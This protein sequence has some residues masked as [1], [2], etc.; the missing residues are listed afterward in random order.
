M[1]ER[2][3]PYGGSYYAVYTGKL[4]GWWTDGRKTCKAT[5]FHRLLILIWRKEDFFPGN[6]KNYKQ[7][8]AL[9]GYINFPKGFSSPSFYELEEKEE[10]KKL[11]GN[12]ASESDGK[13]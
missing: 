7:S 11:K 10:R 3:S 8:G 1:Q 2:I 12:N 6:F 4:K 13:F 9:R 5:L